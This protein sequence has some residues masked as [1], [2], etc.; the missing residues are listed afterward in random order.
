MLSIGALIFNLTLPFTNICIYF[1]KPH[2]PNEVS[3]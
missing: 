3:W 1:G 2:T